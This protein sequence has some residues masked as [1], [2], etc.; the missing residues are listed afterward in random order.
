MIVDRYLGLTRV[1]IHDQPLPAGQRGR[2]QREEDPDREHDGR[3]LR[4][5]IMPSAAPRWVGGTAFII[6]AR[7]GGANKPGPEAVEGDDEREHPVRKSI[8]RNSRKKKIS[9]VSSALPPGIALAPS[10]CQIGRA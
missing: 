4:V 7:F 1:T 8:G 10:G 2:Q 9:A 3:V 6:S 5:A